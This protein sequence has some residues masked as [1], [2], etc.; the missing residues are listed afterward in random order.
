MWRANKR[1]GK[2]VEN[3]LLSS[4]PCKYTRDTVHIFQYAQQLGTINLNPN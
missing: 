2:D 1:E 3:L 4:H